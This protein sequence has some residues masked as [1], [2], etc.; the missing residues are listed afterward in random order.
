[1]SDH[2]CTIAVDSPLQTLPATVAHLIAIR[3]HELYEVRG[4]QEG[5]AVQDWLEAEAEILKHETSVSHHQSIA[6]HHLQ[7]RF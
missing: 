7:R 3:A 2:I 5:R 4:R 1:M 6:D